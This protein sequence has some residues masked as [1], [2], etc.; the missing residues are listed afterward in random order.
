MRLLAGNPGSGLSSRALAALDEAVDAHGA[1][2]A[3][4]LLPTYGDVEHAR[5][6]ALSRRGVG[7]LLDAPFATFTSLAERLLPGTR[8]GMLPT[9]VERDL[10]AGEALRTADVPA[11][12]RVRDRRG[13]RSRFLRLVKEM[14]QTG[15]DPAACRERARASLGALG[16]AARERW[17]GFL[18]AW[19]RYDA[20]LAS[21]GISDHEDVLRGLLDRVRADPPAALSALRFFGADGFDDLTGLEE[22]LL[23]A[24][25]R[26][27]SGKGGAVLA[28]LALD[29]RRPALFAPAIALRDRLVAAGFS[30]ER[31][32]PAR[33]AEDAIA[34][35]SSRLFGPPSPPSEAGSAVRAIVGADP[36]DEIERV[37]R[38]V[39]RLVDPARSDLGP[40]REGEGPLAFRDVGVV[41]RRLDGAGGA[42]GGGVGAFAKRAFEALG[43]PA[44]LAS[45]GTRLASEPVV[46]AFR[47]PLAVLAGGGTGGRDLDGVRLL[48]WLRWRALASGDP[49]PVDLVDVADMEWRKQGFPPDWPAFLAAREHPRW[50]DVLG[51]VEASR[52]ACERAR[53]PD[54]AFGALLDAAER[55]LPLPSPGPLDADGRPLDPEGDE[56]L[57][58]AAHAKRLLLDVARG[59]RSAARRTGLFPGMSAADAVAQ[60]LDALEEAT[61]V[62]ADRRLE[63]VTLLD[64]EEARR[65]DLP[66]VFVVGLV[67]KEF[68]LQPREDVFLHDDDRAAL[69]AGGVVGTGEALRTAR[70]DEE[71]ERR[72]LLQAV[73]TARRRLY[74]CRHAADE[75]GREKAPSLLWREVD[76]VLFARDERGAPASLRGP[77]RVRR[78]VLTTA[79][80]LVPR[81]L[82]RLSCARLG[83]PSLP[84]GEALRAAAVAV[85]R[86][87]AARAGALLRRAARFRRRAEDPLGPEHREAFEKAVES[88]SPTGV[89]SGH[90]CLHRFFLARVLR[91]PEDQA[92][93][94]GRVF[95]RRELG[96]L[97]HEGLRLSLL[98]PDEPSAAVAARVLAESD[99]APA[100][101]TPL[102][103]TVEA[104]LARVVELFRLREARAAGSGFAPSLDHL[105]AAFG[106][107]GQPNVALGEGEGRF[108]LNGKID[109][110]DLLR[111][112]EE[113][114]ASVIDYKLGKS[115][116]KDAVAKALAR[117]DLQ[118]PLYARAAEVAWGLRVV[119]VE[120]YAATGRKRSA[121]FEEEY[122]DR[123]ESRLEGDA[124]K[125]L[126]PEAFRAFLADAER[127]A[128]GVVARVRKGGDGGHEKRPADPE[129]CDRCGHRA[130]CRPDPFSFRR[131]AP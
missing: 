70:A 26:V 46:R 45:G 102:R 112:G 36:G 130:V 2:R 73:S 114:V 52:A 27:V 19:E 127:I 14:K 111:T 94:A 125:P 41:F 48:D 53:G 75:D 82:E 81:D 91:L 67:E 74:L 124:G 129:D 20:R 71:R 22:R 113:V 57:R 21:A 84:G 87:D 30:V 119:A 8:V 28:T 29:E 120:G 64:A 24:C 59:L 85:V 92:P 95:D 101:G 110:I 15:D 97:V 50:R 117:E 79:D 40:R 76:D 35:L 98:H 60:W 33:R 4:L 83:E 25:A 126:S 96:S 11:F 16:E 49:L 100:P 37:A 23:L 34:A 6:V 122:Q 72:L 80:A 3:L 9:R 105:E 44:R 47:G 104:D 58:R 43:V 93:V 13:F 17:A 7:G 109:R 62:L 89:T 88:V 18:D 108:R 131:S 69:L 78:V 107:E 66:V 123:F 31:P 116:A 118:L 128:A 68:P 12:R 54:E 10:L 115:T 5:R 1:D 51:E 55:L 38:E 39:R 86:G 121:T 56:R 99:A 32:P 106:K 77:E 61:F 42:G 63:A 90:R 65:Y 103:A